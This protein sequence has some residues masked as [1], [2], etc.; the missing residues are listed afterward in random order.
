MR[1][2]ILVAALC[3]LLCGSAILAQEAAKEFSGP[4]VGEKVTP[5]SAKG[6]LGEAAGKDFD[7]VKEAEGKPLVIF[8]LHEVNRPSVG[9]AK[10]LLTYAATRQAEGL[11]SGLILLTADATATEEWVKR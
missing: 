11:K 4:Q 7:L 10:T 1:I 3:W 6:V 2:A 8:F 9:L 5:F